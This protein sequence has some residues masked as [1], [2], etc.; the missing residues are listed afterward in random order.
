MLPPNEHGW[1]ILAAERQALLRGEV[2]SHASLGMRRRLG[3]VLIAAGLRLAPGSLPVAEPVA[4]N[5]EGQRMAARVWASRTVSS[6][7]RAG[8]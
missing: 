8:T 5:G 2:R 7:A 6:R 4:K 1:R 3:T